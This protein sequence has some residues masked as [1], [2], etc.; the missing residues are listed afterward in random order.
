V[1]L[2]AASAYAQKSDQKYTTPVPI[3]KQINRHNEDGSYSYG[4]E[5]ADGSFKI[6]TKQANGEV[7]GKYGYVDD[8]GA[9]REIEYG[10]NKN[11]FQP[12]GT[13]INVPP[14]TVSDNRYLSDD[15]DDGQYREDPRIYEDERYNSKPASRPSQQN[16][17]QAPAFKA[18]PIQPAYNQAPAP[19][20]QY[21]QHR[22]QAQAPQQQQ[23]YFEPEPQQYYQ[24]RQQ[25]Q[26]QPQYQQ[27]QQQYQE[28]QPQYQPQQYKAPQN[29]N[30]NPA[31]RN[32]Y[33]NPTSQVNIF[34]GHPASNLDLA[35]GS[36]SVQ[37]KK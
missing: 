9:T 26:Y 23:Q 5:A 31:P 20:K 8:T 33:Y 6:E 13:D 34:R 12:H 1:L 27:P 4:Y 14:P 28:P 30:Y 24:P 22:F 17:K 7:H 37:Y 16:Y 11:G 25:K 18:A 36:Y 15:E 21:N 19:Q 2:F 3:L 10:A 35:S 32:D 29:N